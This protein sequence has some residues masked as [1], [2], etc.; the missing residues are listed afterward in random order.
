MAN[1]T[2]IDCFEKRGK[3]GYIFLIGDEM[4]HDVPKDHIKEY[5]G[6]TVEKDYT[7][8]EVLSM[9]QKMYNVF[10]ILPNM[11]QYYDDSAVNKF[12]K[13]RLGENFIKLDNPEGVAE[14]IAATIGLCEGNVGVDQLEDDIVDA[15]GN[16]DV[17]VAISKSLSTIGSKT[18]GLSKTKLDGTGLTTL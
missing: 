6:T 18:T 9:A 14:L 10:F 13:D 2:S 5:I 11:T 1:H 7:F 12:W 15:G 8:D 17:A 4:S 3:K 16:R